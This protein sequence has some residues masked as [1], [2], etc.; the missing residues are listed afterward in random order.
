MREGACFFVSDKDCFE[1]K[2]VLMEVF[3]GDDMEE[4]P[5]TCF[6]CCYTYMIDQK[7]KD[8]IHRE[9]HTVGCY[10]NIS[11]LLIE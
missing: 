9:V 6:H 5:S 4:E 11:S 1:W 7:H 8:A 2:E 10:K 3:A